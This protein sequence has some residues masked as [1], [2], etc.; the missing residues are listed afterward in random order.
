VPLASASNVVQPVTSAIC[1]LPG[2][3]LVG[4]W[5]SQPASQ[6]QG[7]I[8]KEVWLTTDGVGSKLSYL[9]DLSQVT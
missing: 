2:L 4:L 1:V 6:H 9:A 8:P 7:D 5:P 3:P